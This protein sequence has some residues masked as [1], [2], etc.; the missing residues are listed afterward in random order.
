MALGVSSRASNG[1]YQ[2]RGWAQEALLVRIQYGHKANLGQVK[3]LAKKVYTHQY[4]KLSQDEV[5]KYIDE[6]L[7]EEE[8]EE[9][10][11]EESE[12]VQEENS[13][14]IQNEIAKEIAE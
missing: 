3:A 4:V 11:E 10:V 14:N 9:D 5:Q 12:E 13:E 7:V 6:V 8:D 2:R 1:L